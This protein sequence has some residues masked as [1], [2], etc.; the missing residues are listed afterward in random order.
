MELQIVKQLVP[1]ALLAMEKS[2]DIFINKTTGQFLCPMCRYGG[3]NMS[4]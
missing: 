1:F 3:K 2:E 4:N